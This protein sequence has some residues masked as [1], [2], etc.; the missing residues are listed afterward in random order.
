MKNCKTYENKPV[1]NRAEFEKLKSVLD[2][3]DVKWNHVPSHQAIEGNEEA[4]LLAREGVYKTPISPQ[5]ESEEEEKE[6]GQSGT[7][8]RRW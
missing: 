5:S 2:L 4:D 7:R 6:V 3:L 8:R 1:K